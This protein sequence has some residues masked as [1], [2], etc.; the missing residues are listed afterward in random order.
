VESLRRLGGLD[1]QVACFSHGKPITENAA[2][3]FGKTWGRG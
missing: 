2:A 3:L 1:F